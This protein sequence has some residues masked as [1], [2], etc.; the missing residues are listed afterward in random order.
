MPLQDELEKQGKWLF[1]WRSYLPLLALPLVLAALKDADYLE[2]VFGET[3]EE[4]WHIV[5]FA[6]SFLGLVVRGMTVGHAPK[7]TSGRNTKKQKA[8]TLNTT[9]MYSIMRH[10]LYF[11][12][13][14]IMLG[15]AMFLGVWWLPAFAILIFWLYYERIMIAEEQFLKSKFGDHYLEWANRT[16]LFLPDFKK[17][18]KP[19]LPFSFKTVL[20]REYTGLFVLTTSFALLDNLEDILIDNAIDLPW[21]FIF[22]VGFILYALLRFL[23]KRTR[24][25]YIEGR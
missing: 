7:E 2:R 19:E 22:A 9:G 1:R 23:K 11:G 18:Q 21:V 8:K 12:N 16:P 25:L 20:A 4:L 17:W 3:T 24:F 15:I 6:L 5:C 13:F 10:P 14:L